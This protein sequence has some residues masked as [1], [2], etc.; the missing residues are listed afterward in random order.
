LFLEGFFENYK[1]DT[2]QRDDSELEIYVDAP[3][4]PNKEYPF[5]L[6]GENSPVYNFI[7]VHYFYVIGVKNVEGFF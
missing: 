7:M 5:Y 1:M 2:G 4:L 6:V 3:V